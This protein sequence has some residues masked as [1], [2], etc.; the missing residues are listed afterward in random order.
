MKSNN[1][2]SGVWEH[3]PGLATKVKHLSEREDGWLGENRSNVLEGDRVTPHL[4]CQMC[5]VEGSSIP[6]HSK[7]ASRTKPLLILL[8]AN[9]GVKTSLVK[10]H[11]IFHNVDL[12]NAS[13]SK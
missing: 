1:S 13:C 12:F 4:I 10:K 5:Q 9:D 6:L 2:Y 8:C 11:H 7:P 3:K